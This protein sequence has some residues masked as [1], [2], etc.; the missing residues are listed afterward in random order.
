MDIL[1]ACEV[2]QRVTNE[3]RLLGYNA[4]SCDILETTG[5][6][7]S[8]ISFWRFISKINVFVVKEFKQITINKN[9]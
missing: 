5:S 3:L 2:S 1:V 7:N 6:N 4:F 8:T 9:S